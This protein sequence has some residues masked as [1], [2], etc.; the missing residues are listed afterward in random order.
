MII[1]AFLKGIP[2][3][4][5]LAFSFGPAFFLVIQTALE[6]GFKKAIVTSIGVSSSDALLIIISLMGIS[7][8]NKLLADILGIIASI[9][10]IIYG[11]VMVFSRPDILK[12]RNPKIKDIKSQNEYTKLYFKGFLLNIANPFVLIF[13]ISIAGIVSQSAPKDQFILYNVFFFL[14]ILL[15]VFSMD[16]IKSL[17]AHKFKDFLRPRY[18]MYVNRTIGVIIVILGII[19]IFRTLGILNF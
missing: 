3:G 14:G 2:V 19:L 5:V 9:I 4:L 6:K 16:V 1:D 8:I 17:L 12:Q 13:W 18:M 15:T 7:A 10:L 11:L